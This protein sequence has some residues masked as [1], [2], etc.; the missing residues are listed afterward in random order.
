MSENYLDEIKNYLLEEAKDYRKNILI[1]LK[2]VLEDYDKRKESHSSVVQTSFNNT[3]PF[4]IEGIKTKNEWN[5]ISKRANNDFLIEHKTSRKDGYKSGWFIC[6]KLSKQDLENFIT[7]FQESDI[8]NQIII[9]DY[10]KP[11]EEQFR[12]AIKLYNESEWT[13][14]KRKVVIDDKEYQLKALSS[15]AIGIANNLDSPAN[16]YMFTTNELKNHIKNNCKNFKII[17]SI[18]NSSHDYDEDEYNGEEDMPNETKQIQSL[19]QILYGSP[20]TGKTYNTINKALKIIL[21]N[22]EAEDI[23]KLLNKSF[24]TEEERKKLKNEFEK[25][26]NDGQIEF[27]TFHQSYG[28]EEFI[29]GI[30]ADTNK[31]D[32]VIYKKESGI[33]K[34]L[35]TKSL[36]EYISITK[37]NKKVIEFDEIYNDLLKKIENKEINNLI[38]KSNER[39]C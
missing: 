8:P 29:E 28:Y 7:K 34:K 2:W 35:V 17:D 16:F 36:L 39:D 27:I 3:Y 15:I 20:G 9:W 32:E 14:S 10:K 25:Y 12:E 6:I 11:T 19:N 13:T 33:F 24:H 4:Y 37:E 23:K 26:K 5:R 30:K 31:K 18:N 22:Q 1:Y 21:E 38:L